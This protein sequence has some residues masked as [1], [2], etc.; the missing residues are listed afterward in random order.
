[1]YITWSFFSEK[2]S[3]I[4]LAA[5]SQ[6]LSFNLDEEYSADEDEN[7]REEDISDHD[8]FPEEDSAIF[9]GQHKGQWRARPLLLLT[10]K[11][12]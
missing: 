4:T 3:E 5:S 8:D 7:Q 2:N 9:E 6:D 10:R 12:K 1:M 11:E